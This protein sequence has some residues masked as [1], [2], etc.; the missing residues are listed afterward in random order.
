MKT[1]EDIEFKPLEDL[2]G[3]VSRTHFPNGYGVS[4]VRTDHSYGGTDGLYELAV[5]NSAGELTYDTSVTSDVLG[6]LTPEEVTQ[7]MIEV[8]SLPNIK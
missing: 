2:N 6:H 3:V 8:Q 7:Y 4:V 5:L 1:F